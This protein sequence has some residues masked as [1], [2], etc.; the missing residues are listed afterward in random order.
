MFRLLAFLTIAVF[1]FNMLPS[2][3][4][5]ELSVQAQAKAD[6]K[7]DSS[8]ALNSEFFALGVAGGFLGCLAGSYLGWQ[9]GTAIDD[10]V[11]CG[12]VYSFGNDAQIYGCCCNATLHKL[13][14]L[15]TRSTT[16]AAAWQIA[17]V[18]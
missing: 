14:T 4:V 6:V 16:R 5:Q 11:P 7:K 18:Y 1:A 12:V 2:S 13:K 8:T 17:S 10:S 9:I 15:Q 3:Y